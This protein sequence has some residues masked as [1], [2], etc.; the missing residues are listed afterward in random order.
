MALTCAVNYVVNSGVC[1]SC[2]SPS[3]LC[4]TG[5]LSLGFFDN[6]STVNNVTTNACSS[7]VAGAS[8]CNNAN[9]ALVCLPNYYLNDKSVCIACAVNTVKCDLALSPYSINAEC[10]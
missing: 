9:T 4:A 2:I 5:C 1:E 10:L 3:K 7:C 6:P 8:F